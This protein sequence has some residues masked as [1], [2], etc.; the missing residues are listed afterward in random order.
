MIDVLN[1]IIIGSI[2]TT[3]VFTF[4][5]SN[6]QSIGRIPIPNSPQ[7]QKLSADKQ[8][9]NEISTSDISRPIW[10]GGNN[11]KPWFTNHSKHRYNISS[12]N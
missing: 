2:I 5:V 10:E 8:L 1:V 4:P 9:N 6:E 7:G 11:V 3:N 12:I